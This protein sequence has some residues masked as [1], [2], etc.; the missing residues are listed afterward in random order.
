MRASPVSH[1]DRDLP[2]LLHPRLSTEVHPVRAISQQADHDRR[3]R[4]FQS[5]RRKLSWVSVKP[6]LSACT[7]LCISLATDQQTTNTAKEALLLDVWRARL[8]CD[9]RDKVSELVG[10]ITVPL[11]SLRDLC[12]YFVVFLR[13]LA[14]AF[15]QRLLLDKANYIFA[16]VPTV[17]TNLTAPIRR[18]QR[19]YL[20]QGD[21]RLILIQ[22]D[23]ESYASIRA[24]A[25]KI[26]KLKPG[27]VDYVINNDR[28]A[29]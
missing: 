22:L 27:G 17:P 28:A 12:Q 25:A 14:V 16:T 8:G 24:A 11:V 26:E 9:G 20:D 2:S 15:V 1:T 23:T 19:G 3:E 7:A 10:D 6:A 21:D 4:H 13:S 29:A 5:G 18:L